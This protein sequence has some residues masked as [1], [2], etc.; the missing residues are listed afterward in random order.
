[1][2]GLSKEKIARIEMDTK[3]ETYG[4]ELVCPWCDAEQNESSALDEEG[5]EI[6]CDCCGKSFIYVVHIATSLS[7]HLPEEE[8]DKRVKEKTKK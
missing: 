5:G 6:K 8:L 2:T 4:D 3:T 7:G 1:M